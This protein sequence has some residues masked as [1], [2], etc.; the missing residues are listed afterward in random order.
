MS[1]VFTCSKC[2]TRAAKTFSKQA[3][4]RGAV[5]IVCPGCGARHVI[6]DNLDFFGYGS[7]KEASIESEA[8]RVRLDGD[9]DGASEV[10]EADRTLIE[11]SLE[12]RRRYDEA[13]RK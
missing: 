9:G 3:Y 4:E 2:D 13:K 10:S 1:L 8:K 5:M 11:Q 6:S 7:A 12:E